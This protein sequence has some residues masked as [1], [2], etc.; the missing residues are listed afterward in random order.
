MREM[1]APSPEGWIVLWVSHVARSTVHPLT[2]TVYFIVQ[3]L[4]RS[5]FWLYGQALRGICAPAVYGTQNG[6][7]MGSGCAITWIFAASIIS[8]KIK[9]GVWLT[10]S[11]NWRRSGRGR[12]KHLP[13]GEFS[14]F[15]FIGNRSLRAS[16]KAARGQEVV[17]RGER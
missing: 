13:A 1:P 2:F 14:F 15:K 17:N 16:R 10:F 6:L 11:I 12:G 7:L 9:G 3:N 5:I 8:R 4:T